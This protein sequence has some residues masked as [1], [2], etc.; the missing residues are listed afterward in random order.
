MSV[1]F[2]LISVVL[3]WGRKTVSKTKDN[4]NLLLIWRHHKACKD[5]I[6]MVPQCQVPSHDFY[7]EGLLLLATTR[8][9]NR[10]TTIGLHMH[11]KQTQVAFS[12]SSQF[13]AIVIYVHSIIWVHLDEGVHATFS[14]A[15]STFHC[16]YKALISKGQLASSTIA[17]YH[18]T[19]RRFIQTK[20]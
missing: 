14:S 17:R 9:L 2:L 4:S 6:L 3:H 10:I 11:F 19:S 20:T 18:C 7:I 8:G 13:S 1:L 15:L 5:D 12:N 16:A